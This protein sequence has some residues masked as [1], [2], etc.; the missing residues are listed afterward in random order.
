MNYSQLSISD[1][2]VLMDYYSECAEENEGI[3]KLYNKST[4][5]SR[6]KFK[7][8]YGISSDFSLKSIEVE[9]QLKKRISA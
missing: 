9:E 3:A 8:Y 6:E 7:K 1:L 5:E 2:K 4:D